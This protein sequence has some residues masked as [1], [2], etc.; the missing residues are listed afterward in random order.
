ML[1]SLLNQ[2]ILV[3]E[4]SDFKPALGVA[5]LAML[6]TKQF[7]KTE[8]FKKMHIIRESNVS[9]K[10]YDRLQIRYKFWKK[11]VRVN[12]SIAKEINLSKWVNISKI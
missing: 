4:D 2:N 7:K 12:E 1:S 3:G 11:I 9:K 5:R 6:S 10:I 8:I